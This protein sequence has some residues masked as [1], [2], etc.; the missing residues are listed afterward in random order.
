MRGGVLHKTVDAELIAGGVAFAQ[1]ATGWPRI[2]V[3]AARDQNA[4]AEL[5]H[6]GPAVPAWKFRVADVLKVDTLT[7]WPVPIVCARPENPGCKC[8]DRKQSSEEDGV[9]GSFTI[10]HCRA[11]SPKARHFRDCQGGPLK[12]R[13]IHADCRGGFADNFVRQQLHNGAARTE[14]FRRWRKITMVS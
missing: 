10:F 5:T 9:A 7:V 4:R 6:A 11:V 1:S 2:A 13:A 8:Q 12:E 3:G 14:K